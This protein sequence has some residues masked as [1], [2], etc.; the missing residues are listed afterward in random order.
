MDTLL[1]IIVATLV[2][3]SLFALVASG[4]SLVW[5]TLG[6]FNFAQGSFL[7]IGAYAAYY[8]GTRQLGR[9]GLGA[10]VPASLVL[11]GVLGVIA[12][13]LLVRP[14]VGSPMGELAVIITTLAASTFLENGAQ[15]FFGAT[16]RKLPPL[17]LGHI[18][19]GGSSV[20]WQQVLIIVVAPLILLGLAAFLKRTRVGFAVRAVAQNEDSALLLGIPVT[21][22]YILVF[23]VA[24][25]LAAVAG[26]LFGG[27]YFVTPSMGDNLMLQA[28]VV[29][30]FGGLGSLTGTVMAAYIVGLITAVSDYY[31]GLFWSPAVLVGFLFIAVILRPSGLVASNK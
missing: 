24:A 25:L 20:D 28:F 7:M 16:Y 2:S 27:E 8:I 30:I 29:V 26:I 21:R 31:I 5:G 19:L 9:L 22:I 1:S 6:V 17:L 10:G 14:Y 15:Q 23:S 18:S 3:G 13:F 12:Y 4:L 11:L